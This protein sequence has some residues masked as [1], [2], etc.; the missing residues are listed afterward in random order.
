[1]ESGECSALQPNDETQWVSRRKSSPNWL[2][3]RES[4]ERRCGFKSDT[5]SSSL[6]A[7]SDA[8]LESSA[9]RLR[10]D[11]RAIED[12]GRL[13]LVVFTI[14]VP[15]ASAF[16]LTFQLNP[17]SSDAS[18]VEAGRTMRIIPDA[19]A[20]IVVE[21]IDSVVVVTCDSIDSVGSADVR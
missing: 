21:S 9:S 1:M 6:S 4:G 5:E 17:V 3:C 16:D 19:S 2:M 10:I 14:D 12:R 7:D 8:R 18:S 20:V 15:S 11:I 13:M